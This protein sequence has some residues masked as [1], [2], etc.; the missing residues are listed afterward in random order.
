MSDLSFSEE[1]WLIRARVVAPVTR[2]PLENG[3]VVVRGGRVRAVGHFAE[4]GSRPAS[5]T[6]DLGEVI[7]LP[8]LV[9]AH[10]HLDYTDMAGHLPPPRTF[11]DWIKSILALKAEWD[12]TDYRRSWTRGARMLVQS[13]TTTVGDIEAVADL[14]PEAWETTP[15]RVTSFLEMTG[16]RGRRQPETVLQEAV[17]RVEALAAGPGRTGLSPHAPYSTTAVLM[18]RVSAL[19]QR[20][21]WR[22]ATHVAESH[23]EFE[24][25]T[26]GSGL[27]FDWLRRNEREMSDCGHGSP[28][29]HLERLG[30]LSDHLLAVHVNY[31][32]EGDAELLA[33]RGVSVVHCPRSHD[34][35]GHA[36]FPQAALSRAGV[37]LCLGT[38]SLATVLKKPHESVSLDL[39]A[40]M[41]TLAARW[42]MLPPGTILRMAT[43]N[44]AR[45]LGLAGEVGEL[46]PQC[47]A[48]LIALPWR[49]ALVDAPEAVVHHRGGVIASLIGGRWTVAPD[50]L[51]APGPGAAPRVSS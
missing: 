51:P 6:V 32:A 22:L 15:L 12:T 34:Y 23:E 31:L 38:D 42:P 16:L 5:R 13:G 36:P 30:A 49:G 48:D 9:N 2:P 35:F 41:R 24:M 8:G 7:L 3:A 37:N 45:A 19:A 44:G 29:Q 43:V 47:Q 39:F 11:P 21:G 26:R 25:F 10:C 28:V 18:R 14:L 20:R 46:A 27:M 17:R 4:L 50:T 33:R 40:E 1:E